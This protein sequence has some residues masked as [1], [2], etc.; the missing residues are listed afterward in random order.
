MNP[1]G[2]VLQTSWLWQYLQYSASL[3]LCTFPRL[4]LS[5]SL[6]VFLCVFMSAFLRAPYQI[7]TFTDSQSTEHRAKPLHPLPPS[8]CWFAWTDHLVFMKEGSKLSASPLWPA[9]ILPD[10]SFT[11]TFLVGREA[12]LVCVRNSRG[13]QM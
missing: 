6:S 5:G 7:S 10:L 4:V 9:F 2:C 11:V 12:G 1:C 8:L 13:A 3:S